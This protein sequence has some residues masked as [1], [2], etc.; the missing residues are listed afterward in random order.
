MGLRTLIKDIS[1]DLYPMI[2]SSQ[3]PVQL[4][5]IPALDNVTQGLPARALILVLK[6]PD[7]EKNFF[8]NQ[9]LK[10][11]T[12]LNSQICYFLANQYMQSGLD[13][14]APSFKPEFYHCPRKIP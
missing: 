8:I 11:R 12:L 3:N 7:E 2:E 1:E 5:G 4:T 13:F 10:Y 14:L 9:I 6:K